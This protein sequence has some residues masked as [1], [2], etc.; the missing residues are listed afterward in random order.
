M[1]QAQSKGASGTHSNLKEE[2]LKDANLKG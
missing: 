2:W 1:T